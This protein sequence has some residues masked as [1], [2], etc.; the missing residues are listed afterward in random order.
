MDISADELAYLINQEHPEAVHTKDFWCGHEVADG[1]SDRISPAFIAEWKLEADPPTEARLQELYDIHKDALDA[2]VEQRRISDLLDAIDAERDRRIAD[3][4]L[5]EG[6]LYQSRPGDI[7]KISRWAASA[8]S[9]IEA[10]AASGDYRWHGQ[11]YDFAWIAADN[12]THRLDASAMV[13]LGEAV[14]THE[15][16][17][18]LA[19][20]TIKDMDPIPEGYSNDSHWQG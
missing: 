11:D 12:T 14:L 7:D 9:A 3:G 13:A 19:A 5:F 1:T 6:V 16:A 18:I 8:R 2:I 15:Q 10:G 20:R 17:H 4:F